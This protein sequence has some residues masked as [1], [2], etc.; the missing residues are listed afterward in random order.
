VLLE[1]DAVLVD[2]SHGGVP[3]RPLVDHPLPPGRADGRPQA[4]L[5]ERPVAVP[6]RTELPEIGY[7]LEARIAGA[8]AYA[9]PTVPNRVAFD[10]D[11]LAG[12]LVVRARRPGDRFVPFGGVE[13]RLKTLLIDAKVPR[14]DRGR[15]PVVEAGGAIVWVGNL[16][17]GSAARVTARTR[18]VLELALVPLA[19]PDR[20]R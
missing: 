12:A 19:K 5:V 13:R 3:P 6:G 8:D 9:I 17:R 2:G 14:W 20:D 16:R 10:A 4:G 15:V 1:E 11:E 7:A 18:R